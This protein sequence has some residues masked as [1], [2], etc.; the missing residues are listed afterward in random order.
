MSWLSGL[1][2]LLRLGR[3]DTDVWPY[4]AGRYRIVDPNAPVVVVLG[5]GE[6]LADD[7]V[8]LAAGGL[9]LVAP[10]CRNANDADKLLRN[11]AANLAIQ[12]VVIAGGD[13]PVL[14]A[15]AAILSGGELT[16]EAASAIATGIRSKIADLDV[17]SLIRQ[18]NTVDMRGCTEVDKIIARVNELAAAAGRPNTGFRAPNRNGDPRVERV[19]AA[20]HVDHEPKGDKAGDYKIRLEKDRIVIEHYNSKQELLRTIEGGTARDLCITVVRN[21]WVSKLDHAAYLGRE[22]MRAELALQA[23]VPYVQDA[24]LTSAIAE[25]EE[26]RH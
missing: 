23:G 15:L 9:C 24:L 5:P 10:S 12:H 16:Q 4:H 25:G 3:R 19:I 8:G 7:I 21:G 18:V 6:G 11:I 13:D 2:T 17:D 1:Q 14:G 26:T 20:S 22:L